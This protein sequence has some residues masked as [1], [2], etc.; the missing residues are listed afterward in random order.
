MELSQK[1]I[2]HLRKGKK[3]AIYASTLSATNMFGENMPPFVVARGQRL[4]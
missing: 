2:G 4:R 3:K 1:L